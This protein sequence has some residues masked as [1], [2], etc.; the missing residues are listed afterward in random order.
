MSLP[1]EF[2]TRASG[3]KKGR[4]HERTL[5]PLCLDRIDHF[6]YQGIGRPLVDI[7]RQLNR[8]ALVQAILKELDAGPDGGL[9]II[10]IVQ[11][12]NRSMNDM[13]IQ[14]PQRL[15][16]EIIGCEIW[17]THVSRDL[18]DDVTQGIGELIHLRD[19]TVPV[20]RGE[21]RMRPAITGCD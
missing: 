19:D 2:Q 9:G 10:L 16:C 17:R 15:Q 18:A 20:E 13:E 1:V 4:R 7:M 12:V 14:L 6:L 11:R 21:V 5:Q 3:R 8:P